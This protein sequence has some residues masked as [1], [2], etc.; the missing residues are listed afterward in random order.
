MFYLFLRTWTFGDAE[1]ICACVELGLAA[2]GVKEG[3]LC[4]NILT[5]NGLR[6]KEW[7]PVTGIAEALK[8]EGAASLIVTALRTRQAT[9][10]G[11]EGRF[12]MEF[13]SAYIS[14]TSSL[15]AEPDVERAQLQSR[16]AGN[17][18]FTSISNASVIRRLVEPPAPTLVNHRFKFVGEPNEQFTRSL[19][20]RI[21]LFMTG[22]RGLS[23]AGGIDLVREPW[24]RKADEIYSDIATNYARLRDHFDQMHKVFFES[25]ACRT[26][27]VSPGSPGVEYMIPP[28][29]RA[30]QPVVLIA[31]TS[32]DD[33]RAF[34]HPIVPTIY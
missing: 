14:P 9:A 22:R 7:I 27:A 6:E 1:D 29:P 13:L 2:V 21:Y 23:L 11:A 34:E 24:V 31:R 20:E 15:W 16:A 25:Q 26:L 33:Y 32:D 17:A 12:T 30:R 19:A 18:A 28:Q 3:S 8:C 5:G 4:A 10:R